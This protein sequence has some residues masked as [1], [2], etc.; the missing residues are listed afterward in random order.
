LFGLPL[1]SLAIF[2]V[3]IAGLVLGMVAVV[4]KKDHALFTYLPLLTGAY[5]I[6]WIAGE[7]LYPH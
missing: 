7:L 1:M 2:G 4:I 5:C 3:G 6:F